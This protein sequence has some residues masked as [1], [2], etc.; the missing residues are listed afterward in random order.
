[1]GF[2]TALR[3]LTILPLPFHRQPKPH[4]I[5]AS[6]IYFPIVGLLVGAILFLANWGMNNILSP[7]VSAALTL[8]LWVLISGAMHLDA[9]SDA[10]DGLAGANPVRRLEIMADSHIGTYGVVGVVLVL[11]LKYTAI[12]SLPAGWLLKAWLLSPAL[13]NWAMVLVISVFPYAHKTGGLGQYFKQGASKLRLA[14]ATLI[15]LIAVLL[16]AGWQGLILVGIIFL[17]A[18]GTG[19]F[20]STR[21]NGLTGDIYGSI[22]EI[23][24]VVTLLIIPLIARIAL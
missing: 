4:E 20:F 16:L 19:R 24:E 6:L 21:L 3:F 9:V 17:C 18:I 13:G 23:T 2:L 5:G 12:I 11:L 7:A 8:A 1:M 22:K 15:I 10:S 14:I